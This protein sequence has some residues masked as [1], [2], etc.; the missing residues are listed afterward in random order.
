[1]KVTRVYEVD[2]DTDDLVRVWDV[3]KKHFATEDEAKEYYVGF[4]DSLMSQADIGNEDVY[5]WLVDHGVDPDTKTRAIWWQDV[6]GYAGT[7]IYGP[8]AGSAKQVEV[9]PEE[10]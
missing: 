10:N 2:V 4:L 6:P 7:T 5:L 8:V 3:L 1:M 9:I